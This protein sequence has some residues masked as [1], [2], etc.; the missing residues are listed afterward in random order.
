MQCADDGIFAVC[1]TY[2][3]VRHG[4]ELARGTKLSL[5]SVYDRRLAA[6]FGGVRRSSVR[7][8]VFVRSVA[9]GVHLLTFKFLSVR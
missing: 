8:Y 5:H 6:P 3:G 7:V 4:S 2:D 1:V 9:H